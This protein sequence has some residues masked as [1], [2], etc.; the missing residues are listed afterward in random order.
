M[1]LLDFLF[2]NKK[3]REQESHVEDVLNR[4]DKTIERIEKGL[5]DMKK[6]D[7]NWKKIMK[8]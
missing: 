3:E 2:K 8:F 7:E 1:G 6:D 4:T 5:E